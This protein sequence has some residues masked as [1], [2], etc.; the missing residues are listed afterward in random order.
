MGLG[1]E[2]Q[3]LE[4]EIRDP[5]NNLSRIQVSKRHR[6]PDPDPQHWY[7]PTLN[8]SSRN[9]SSVLLYRYIGNIFS[10]KEPDDCVEPGSVLR[11]DAAASRGGDCGRHHG[12]QVCQCGGGDPHP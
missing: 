9:D 1:S 10:F 5:E 12:H 7:F 6:I 3:D 11:A 2:I 8:V 4:S